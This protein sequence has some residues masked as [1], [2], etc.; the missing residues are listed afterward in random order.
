[1]DSITICRNKAQLLTF[2]R[3]IDHSL[4]VPL[5]AR[6][7]LDAYATGRLNNG[8]IFAINDGEK[9]AAAALFYYH[10][11]TENAAYL[12]LLAT[13]PGYYGRGYAGQLLDA[14]HRQAKTDGMTEIH[15]HT[16]DVNHAAISL[17]TKH[18]YEEIARDP[19]V[20]MRKI[21]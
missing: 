7:D 15:L 4:P 9:I 11:R 6:V 5:S 16:N 14:M 8:L 10:F 18:G 19:K 3:E 2:L 21:L 13:A 17:Y 12:D 20:H 1:M